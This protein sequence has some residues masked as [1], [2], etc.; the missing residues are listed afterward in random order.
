MESFS[1]P[2]KASFD[3]G[4]TRWSVKAKKVGGVWTAQVTNPASGAVS[5]RASA[6]GRSNASARVTDTTGGCTDVTSIRAYAIG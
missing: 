3:G 5:L 4:K 6:P 2:S 1:L